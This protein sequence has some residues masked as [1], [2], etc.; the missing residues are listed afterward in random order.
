MGSRKESGSQSS[1][2]QTNGA[3]HDLAVHTVPLPLYG[4]RN[5]SIIVGTVRKRVARARKSSMEGSA[6]SAKRPLVDYQPQMT[7]DVEERYPFLSGD[8]SIIGGIELAAPFPELEESQTLQPCFKRRREGTVWRGN[9]LPGGEFPSPA[10]R[11][12]EHLLSQPSQGLTPHFLPP[13][14][15]AAD[16]LLRIDSDAPEAWCSQDLE[17][18]S[19]LESI[20]LPGGRTL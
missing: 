11:P 12:F 17:V 20:E 7:P 6:A 19:I 5:P 13:T 14:F 15:L 9:P 18:E 1:P 2:Q 3:P 4:P 16:A 8:P 10:D